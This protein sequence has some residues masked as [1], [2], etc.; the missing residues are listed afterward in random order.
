MTVDT[1]QTDTVSLANTITLISTGGWINQNA[2]TPATTAN[3][4]GDQLYLQAVN[5]I[6]LNTNVSVLTATN[7]GGTDTSR[8]SIVLHNLSTSP[9]S[10]S[11][12]W[13]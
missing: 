6:L 10:I 7:S 1:V 5:G 12:S 4:I 9:S 2:A 3:I 11:V 13:R 8:A